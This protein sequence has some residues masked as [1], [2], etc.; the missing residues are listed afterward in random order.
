MRA[1]PRPG[2]AARR[3]RGP[4]PRGSSTRRMPLSCSTPLLVERALGADGDAPAEPLVDDGD[5]GR[6]QVVDVAEL[7]GRRRSPCTVSS[8]GAS[9]CR[10]ITVSMPGPTSAAGR[11]HGD[12]RPGW[13]SRAPGQ[14]R[15]TSSRSPTS[16]LVRHGAAAA[17]PRAAAPGCPPTRRT[18]WRSSPRPRAPTAGRRRRGD[19]RSARRAYRPLAAPGRR[20]AGRRRGRCWSRR[21]RARRRRRRRGG[22]AG[23][24]R[25]TDPPGR[26]RSPVPRV[27]R[28]TADDRARRRPPAGGAGQEGAAATAPPRAT[29]P[30]ATAT[31]PCALAPRANPAAGETHW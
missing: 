4:G 6:G 1:G 17:R 2:A 29:R 22:T 5:H 21:A 13:T 14:H 9:K 31:R 20:P 8:R 16:A 25:S 12:V 3:S 24:A 30:P 23:A 28:R 7:P 27:A 18:S 15:S 19:Q 26:R 11:T 10:V